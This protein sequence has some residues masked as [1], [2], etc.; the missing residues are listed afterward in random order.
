[1]ETHKWDAFS[2]GTQA[3]KRCLVC[4]SLL[5]LLFFLSLSLPFPLM[6]KTIPGLGGNAQEFLDTLVDEAKKCE[7]GLS[8]SCPALCL[9]FCLPIC[10]F[11]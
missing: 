4:L 2:K 7:G 11:M 8:L 6:S 10:P 1:M 9:S 3:W 5:F